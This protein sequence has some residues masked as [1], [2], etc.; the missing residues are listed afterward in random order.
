MKTVTA[1]IEDHVYE[2]L[3]KISSVRIKMAEHIRRAIDIYLSTPAIQQEL[4][5]AQDAINAIASGTM[6]V[7]DAH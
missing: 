2:D 4:A 1:R 5:V 7:I 6:G 3:A